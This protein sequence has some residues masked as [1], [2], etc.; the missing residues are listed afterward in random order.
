MPLRTK[1]GINIQN[2]EIKLLTKKVYFNQTY[3]SKRIQP[4]SSI[5][6]S[7]WPLLA[8]TLNSL[9]NSPTSC[10]SKIV[11]N[12][13]DTQWSDGTQMDK[14]DRSCGM[15]LGKDCSKELKFRG[16]RHESF[17]KKFTRRK[18]CKH[19]SWRARGHLQRKKTVME[20]GKRKSHALSW[21]FH[22]RQHE[23]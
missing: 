12:S 2:R 16:R 11:K 6:C 10:R 17:S 3:I 5:T 4:Q 23:Y 18:K 14:R 7:W 15:G 19:G 22:W 1:N 20:S 9:T 8:A 13:R 21:C